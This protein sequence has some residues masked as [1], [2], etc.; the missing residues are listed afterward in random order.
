M[1][2]SLKVAGKEKNA[3]SIYIYI[4]IYIYYFSY[5]PSLLNIQMKVKYN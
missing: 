4:Y 3:K 2:D 1:I 5:L